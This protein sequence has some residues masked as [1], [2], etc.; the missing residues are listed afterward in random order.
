MWALGRSVQC[1]HFSAAYCSG[2]HGADDNVEVSSVFIPLC[3]G[4][5]SYDKFDAKGVEILTPYV[6]TSSTL[7]TRQCCF[8][9]IT[10]NKVF[11]KL[12]LEKIFP[13]VRVR[14]GVGSVD[15]SSVCT[16]A[17]MTPASYR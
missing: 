16:L 11:E 1:W 6:R 5:P 14:T 2:V 12:P 9:T 13:R 17:Y 15:M 10:E 4:N 3:F 8:V 7:D